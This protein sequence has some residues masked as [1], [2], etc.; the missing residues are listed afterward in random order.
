MLPR[1][2]V[3]A[4]VVALMF[5]VPIG[6]GQTAPPVDEGKTREEILK[7]PG[8][9][10]TMYGH[11]FATNVAGETPMPMNTQF[12]KGEADLSQGTSTL[13]GNPPPA[14][15]DNE[16]CRTQT[17]NEQR[18]YSTAGFVQVKNAEE[19]GSDYGKFHNERG[20]TK[21]LFLDPSVPITAT[22]YM[23][24]DYHGWLVAL[25]VTVC[26]NWDPGYYQDWVVEAT[27]MHAS[28]G[29]LHTNASEKPPMAD[30]RAR[31]EGV[32]VVAHGMS[33]PTDMLSIDDTVPGLAD[34]TVTE[35]KFDLEWDPAF[36]ASGA[37]IPPTDNLI[38]EWEWYQKTENPAGGTNEYILGTTA[39]GLV[40]NL[41][42]GEDYPANILVPVRNPI[43][44]EL[45]YPQFIHDK[46]VILS[47]INTPWGSY[48][49]DPALIKLEVKDEAGN[50]VQVQD[51]TIVQV[52][53]QSVAHSGHYM[54]IKP[55][56]VWDY[57]KQGL[58]PGDYT[59]TVEVTNFQH[60]V[61]TAT[62]AGFS[63]TSEG[64]GETKEGRSG[65][66]TLKGNLHAG[67]EGT[68]A[69][70]NSVGNT[71][72]AASPTSTEKSP[73]WTLPV[74][75]LGLLIVALVGRRRQ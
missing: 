53:E 37:M 35:F 23:S 59:V 68:A 54:P 52:V 42:T 8:K 38:V 63:V 19:W 57:Q 25:C 44:V 74:V 58:K 20:L 27:V 51:D 3:V 28:L 49:I 56:W 71:T 10:V 14:P 50:K 31:A 75:V 1:I 65:L 43:D 67:H 22:Y 4:A 32:V 7:A 33:E 36:V 72:A 11:M 48:D 15:A 2:A 47:V 21:D 39:A 40:W 69:D 64:A 60:S 41:D 26:W 73:G 61:T 5:L 12:P 24:P 45:V 46:L 6:L 18:W 70:P 16:D 9:M 13:C 55:T 17:S 62:T 29:P 30:V 34:P 66:Q